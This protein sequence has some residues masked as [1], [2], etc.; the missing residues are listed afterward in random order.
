MD[1]LNV[2]SLAQAKL[3][4]KIDPDY[5]DDDTIIESLIKS[6]VNQI[7]KFTLQILYYRVI[8]ARTSV[9]GEYKI[10]EYPLISVESVIDADTDSVV[11]EETVTDWYTNVISSQTNRQTVT[12]IAGYGWTYDGG[13]E[14]PDDIITAIKE[15]VTYLYENRDNAK[16]AMP[17]IVQ[18][19]L[20]PYRRITLF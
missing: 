10:Y 13:T 6:A 12:F 7:E 11:F 9:H 3:W 19:L 15:Y 14:V 17:A 4:L 2:V 18:L 16:L 8:T 20:A 5:D 1:A